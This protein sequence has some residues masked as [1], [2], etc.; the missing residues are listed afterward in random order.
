MYERIYMSIH[1]VLAS[2]PSATDS[3]NRFLAFNLLS[4]E[5]SVIVFSL[6]RICNWFSLRPFHIFC[7]SITLLWL[8]AA[9]FFTRLCQL[10][11]E[12]W[13][14]KILQLNQRNHK[15]VCVCVYITL[16]SCIWS[17]FSFSYILF[18]DRL[19]LSWVVVFFL[20]LS[21]E[22]ERKSDPRN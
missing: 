21:C 15:S 22:A 10:Q 19:S 9:F 3:K 2:P 5:L 7:C 16:I 14:Q 13:L 20:F 18:Y 11:S 8:C 4:C 1:F 12:K 17:E 6:H